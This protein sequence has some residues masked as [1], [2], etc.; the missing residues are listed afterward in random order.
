MSLRMGRHLRT[1]H[2]FAFNVALLSIAIWPASSAFFYLTGVDPHQPRYSTLGAFL[3][4]L[5]LF[6]AGVF[7]S[8]S[9]LLAVAL[10]IERG[11]VRL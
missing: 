11:S 8:N 4:P 7:I 3:G 10:G 9:A 6:A 2:R 1:A 5:Y